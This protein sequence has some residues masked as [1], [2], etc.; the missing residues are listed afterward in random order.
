M[1]CPMT[2]SLY[3]LQSLRYIDGSTEKLLLHIYSDWSFGS[4]HSF[5]M[6]KGE[7]LVSGT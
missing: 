4:C 7:S 3:V 2:Q 6:V 1:R 5:E